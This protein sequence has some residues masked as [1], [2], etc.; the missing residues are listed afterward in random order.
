MLLNPFCKPCSSFV[1]QSGFAGGAIN[2]ITRSGTNK[3]SGSA[4]GYYRD[5]SLAGKT[6]EVLMQQQER[7]IRSSFT[8]YSVAR[9]G[10]PIIEDK[11][12]FFVNYER[13]DEESPRFF[14]AAATMVI[15]QTQI[16]TLRQ[17]L[18]DTSQL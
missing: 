17:N 1:R 13:Q 18:I 16:G 11:L 3:F 6:Q 2:A 12:F 14:D 7:K 8:A 9:I 4:Y 15:H 5:E 10:G